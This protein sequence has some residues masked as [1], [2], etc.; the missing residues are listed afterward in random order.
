MALFNTV[1][2]ISTPESDHAVGNKTPLLLDCLGP[3]ILIMIFEQVSSVALI[4][5]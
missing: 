1:T 5:M 3:E 4:S 2:S